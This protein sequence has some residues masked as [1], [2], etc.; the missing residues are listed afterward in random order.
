MFRQLGEC[1]R[2]DPVTAYHRRAVASCARIKQL[3]T[4]RSQDNMHLF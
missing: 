3:V 4:R 2:F 1:R